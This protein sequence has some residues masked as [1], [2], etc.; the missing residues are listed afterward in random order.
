MYNK[1]SNSMSFSMFGTDVLYIDFRKRN[2]RQFFV[3]WVAYN[4]LYDTLCKFLSR[5]GYGFM[6]SP[7]RN[8]E[9][10][11]GFGYVAEVIPEPDDVDA[12]PDIISLCNDVVKDTECMINELISI[13]GIMAENGIKLDHGN[14]NNRYD[15]TDSMRIVC[16]LEISDTYSDGFISDPLLDFDKRDFSSLCQQDFQLALDDILKQFEKARIYEAQNSDY[17][18]ELD[19]RKAKICM[20][21]KAIKYFYEGGSNNAG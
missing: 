5:A 10:S 12:E 18:V 21:K 19:F 6:H 16:A 7:A 9:T 13:E 11:H 8:N 14:T 15:Y 20:C 2:G 1:K 17:V 4:M 3:I